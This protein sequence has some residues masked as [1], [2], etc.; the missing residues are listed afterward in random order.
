MGLHEPA[1]G[2]RSMARASTDEESSVLVAPLAH[3][4]GGRVVCAE[5]EWNDGAQDALPTKRNGAP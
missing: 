1:V 3:R 5:S 2:N 4:R